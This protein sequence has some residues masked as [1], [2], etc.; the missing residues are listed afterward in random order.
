MVRVFVRSSPSTL[1]ALVGRRLADAAPVRAAGGGDRLLPESPCRAL[2]LR[3]RPAR[4]IDNSPTEREF[5][6]LAELA[7]RHIAA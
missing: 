7:A 4:T 3:R 1:R 6:K 5:Q 2:P